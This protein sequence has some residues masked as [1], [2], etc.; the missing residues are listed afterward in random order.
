MDC[1]VVNHGGEVSPACGL[2]DRLGF[3]RSSDVTSAF[4]GIAQ[5]HVDAR[6][7]SALRWETQEVLDSANN[8]PNPSYRKRP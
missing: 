3:V 8:S 7:E 1:G 2:L 5:V 6:F 4:S